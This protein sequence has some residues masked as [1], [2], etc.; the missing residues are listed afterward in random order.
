MYCSHIAQYTYEDGSIE[1]GNYDDGDKV[2]NHV[3]M[4]T[5]GMFLYRNLL[6]A[7][8]CVC[9]CCFL[10]VDIYVYVRFSRIRS[11][12]WFWEGDSGL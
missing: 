7:C 3:Y 5:K 8:M 4:Y 9:L 10:C 6:C 12:R 11:I 2:G 1:L